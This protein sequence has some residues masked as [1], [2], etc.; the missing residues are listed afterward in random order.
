MQ[1]GCTMNCTW[2]ANRTGS[3]KLCCGG[4]EDFTINVLPSTNDTAAQEAES[5]AVEER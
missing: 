1:E 5:D 3:T 4:L 2:V